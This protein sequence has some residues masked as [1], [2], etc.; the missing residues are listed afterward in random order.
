MRSWRLLTWLTVFSVAMAFMESSIVIYL[1]ELLYPGGFSFPLAEM[2]GSLAITEI[3]RELS[4]LIM[5]M[6]VAFIAGKSFSMRFALFIYCFAVWDIFYYVFLFLLI[7]WPGSLLEWDILFLLPLTWT[8]PVISP[9]IITVL[10]ISLAMIIVYNSDRGV[11]TGIKKREWLILIAGALVVIM[12][13]TWD[14]SVYILEEYSIADLWN[15]PLKGSLLEYAYGYIPRCFNWGLF[16]AG[17]LIIV[18]AILALSL[19]FRFGRMEHQ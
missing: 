7:G 11:D 5:L 17:V 18:Y 19:R 9:L 8:G 16:T 14:Y 2:D 6:A 15:L 13:F 1:R 4:T 12:A 3:L 10:M